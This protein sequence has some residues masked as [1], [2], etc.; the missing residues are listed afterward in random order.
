MK[1]PNPS[2]HTGVAFLLLLSPT[3]AQTDAAQP[4]RVADQFSVAARCPLS[5]SRDGNWALFKDYDALEACNKTILLDLN[6]YNNID[7]PSSAMG[8]RACAADSG[9]SQLK[10][11]QE[12]VV[13]S[14]NSATSSFD[15]EQIAPDIQVYQDGSGGNTGSVQ[16]AISA[17]A[18]RVSG[19]G[20]GSTTALFAKSGDVV[21]G[22]YGGLQISN[23]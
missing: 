19:A 20:D 17:L 10:A 16:S 1:S 23:Q 13:A 3:Q 14:S 21:V 8:I 7:G 6:L 12:F 11:R 18:S 9:G 5:C 4:G 15:K 22:V 2:L